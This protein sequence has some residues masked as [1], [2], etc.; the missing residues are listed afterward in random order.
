[1]I[2]RCEQIRGFAT[3]QTG[4]N[5]HAVTQTF[6]GGDHVRQNVGVLI[7]KELTRPRIAALHFVQNQQPVV[8]IANAAQGCQIVVAGYVDTAFAKNRLHHNCHH[9]GIV[10]GNGFNSGNVVK[11]GSYKAAE[12][13]LKARVYL[14]VSCG[15][16]GCHGA[17]VKTAVYHNHRRRLNA[18]VVAL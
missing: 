16:Q 9:I 14:A 4:S 6:R 2:A 18:L 8:G 15:G 7:R 5:G 10:C 17:A 1:M 11:R 13:G 12:Q 3:G